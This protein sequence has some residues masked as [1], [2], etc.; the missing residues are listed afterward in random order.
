IPVRLETATP[1][2]Q[3]TLDLQADRQQWCVQAT[4]ASGGR[5]TG[6]LFIRRTAS[7]NGGTLMGSGVPGGTGDAWAQ[8]WSRTGSPDLFQGTSP[9]T[10]S[11]W[12]G[13]A[14]VL[15]APAQ[16]ADPLLVDAGAGSRRSTHVRQVGELSNSSCTRPRRRATS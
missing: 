11:V 14:H 7:G 10:L 6:P 2:E 3:L 4:E 15:V 13:E 16:T 9:L 1:A 5:P 8:R 12:V